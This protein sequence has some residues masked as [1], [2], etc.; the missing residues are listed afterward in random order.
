MAS[1]YD[2]LGVA[3]SASQEELRTAF[4]QRARILHPDVSTDPAAS[5]AM[6]RLNEVWAV[7][8]D[9]EARRRYDEEQREPVAATFSPPLPTVVA[10]PEQFEESSALLYLLFR[11]W[12]IIPAILLLILVVAAYAGHSGAGRPN[13]ATTTTT[14]A[15]SASAFV[16]QCV[17]VQSDSVLVVACSQL[18]NSLVIAAVPTAAACPAG[19]SSLRLTGQTEV[20]C[21]KPSTP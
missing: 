14:P 1:L 16:G 13:P 11:P 15:P 8:G 18:P 10:A 5:E 21:A 3:S 6:R 20:L 19:S 4:R 17:Q 12:V 9:P 2:E 7:L